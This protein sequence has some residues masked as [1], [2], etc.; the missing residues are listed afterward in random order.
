MDVTLSEARAVR[1][2]RNCLYVFDND[3]RSWRV[4]CIFNVR[5][6]CQLC[7][8]PES[9]IIF[10]SRLP[11]SFS[12]PPLA[13]SYFLLPC[14]FAR[15]YTTACKATCVREGTGA[16]ITISSTTKYFQYYMQNHIHHGP[17]SKN[18]PSINTSSLK[19]ICSPSVLGRED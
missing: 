1:A 12:M 17:R 4:L 18:I 11:V 16:S 14:R 6:S 3:L 15:D 9:I 8:G 5:R 2:P 19:Q 7:F 13:L 10:L